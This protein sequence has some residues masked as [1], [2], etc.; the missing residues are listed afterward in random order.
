MIA[1]S[2]QEMKQCSHMQ[3]ELP[4]QHGD[5]QLVCDSVPLSHFHNETV[6]QMQFIAR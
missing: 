2:E 3:V 6:E 5:T 1:S 4:R